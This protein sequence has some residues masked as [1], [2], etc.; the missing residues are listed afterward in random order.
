MY[1]QKVL[2]NLLILFGGLVIGLVIGYFF[3]LYPSLARKNEDPVSFLQ[4]QFSKKEVIGFLPY[5]LL[6]K[7]QTDYSQY[8][9]TLTYFGLSLDSDGKILKLT[10]PQETEPGWQALK[11]GKVQPFL[12][13][14]LQHHQKLSLLIFSGNETTISSLISDPVPHAQ[15]LIAEVK[16]LM[17]QY[18]F[19]DLN[20]DIESTQIAS[21]EARLKFSQFIKEVK[22]GVVNN[23]LGTL[24]IEISPD[25]VVKKNLIDLASV[26]N[27]VDYIVLM[28]YDYHYIGSLVTGP[29]APLF[30]AGVISEFD[31]NTALSE[32][33]QVVPENKI[34]LGVP[35]YGYEW[36][37]INAATR[38]ATIPS[39][40]LTASTQRVDQLL[41]S[42]ASCSAKLDLD[43]KENFLIYSDEQTGTFHQIFYPDQKSTQSKIDFARQNNL[44][45]LALWALGYED[46]EILNPLK[47]YK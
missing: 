10:N 5:W 30:G 47:N 28:S 44:A 6:S 29:V 27:F 15:N 1:N 7:A 2:K 18:K 24:T 35:L 11:S 17:Q 22:K 19:T 20:L 3:I 25:S 26:E 16:P 9:T 43:A 12:S 37:T 39:S 23:Q 36:E 42:C 21:D 31:T 38:S 33:L 45:G 8:I 4:N 40:G 32:T 13:S 34:I 14:A 46:L 41:N